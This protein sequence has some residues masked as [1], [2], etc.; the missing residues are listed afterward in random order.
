MS[1][2]GAAIIISAEELMRWEAKIAELDVAIANAQIERAS[3]KRK[4]EA[5]QTL[6]S[7][8]RDAQQSSSADQA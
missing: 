8:V 3:I 4:L 5:A 7:A 6:L 2:E 1:D